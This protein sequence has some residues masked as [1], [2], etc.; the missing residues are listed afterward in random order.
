M[1]RHFYGA[2]HG[3]ALSTFDTTC[4]LGL[5]EPRWAQKWSARV[6]DDELFLSA[7]HTLRFDGTEENFRAVLDEREHIICAHVNTER[8]TYERP[9]QIF[10]V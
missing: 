3:L 6:I 10:R 8:V 2:P 5:H 1:N 9:S 4:W 7:T